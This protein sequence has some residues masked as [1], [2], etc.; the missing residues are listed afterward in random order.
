[1]KLKSEEKELEELLTMFGNKQFECG[2]FDLKE[3]PIEDYRKLVED[4]KLLKGD[5]IEFWRES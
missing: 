1:M 3:M 2:I 5:I 4:A